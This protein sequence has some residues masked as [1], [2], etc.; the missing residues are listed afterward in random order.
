MQAWGAK[1]PALMLSAGAARALW[2][3]V[4]DTVWGEIWTGTGF[5]AGGTAYLTA[6]G[7][8][9][10]ATFTAPIARQAAANQITN[11]NG[12]NTP[13]SLPAGW[14]VGNPDVY[15]GYGMTDVYRGH[16]PERRFLFR[17]Y[18]TATTGASGYYL[19]QPVAAT[20]WPA[21]RTSIGPSASM[22]ACRP[23]HWRM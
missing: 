1:W 15:G 17:L 22:R 2:F 16:R 5:T 8:L 6:C 3:S 7:W 18:G 4:D 11:P 19:M 23:D 21:R 14:S 12:T 20:A 10:G 9:E 13:G